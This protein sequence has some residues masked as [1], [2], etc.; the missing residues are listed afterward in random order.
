MVR[1]LSHERP[2]RT[3]EVEFADGSTSDYKPPINTVD[4]RYRACTDHHVG[5]DCREA[6]LREEIVE[7]KAVS[8][9]YRTENTRLRA[10]CAELG[11]KLTEAA[12]IR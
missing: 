4:P 8:V 7:L 6:D 1:F 9:E 12:V 5:C 11:A 10:L 2:T 3:D